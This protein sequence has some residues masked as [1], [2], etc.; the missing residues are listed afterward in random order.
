MVALDQHILVQTRTNTN[1][2]LIRE[3]GGGSPEFN[4]Q[5]QN[6]GAMNIF[7]SGSTWFPDDTDCIGILSYDASAQQM[8]FGLMMKRELMRRRFSQVVLRRRKWRCSYFRPLIRQIASITQ[9]W[10]MNILMIPR[11]QH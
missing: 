8:S 2:I 6:S 9:V 5:Q 10:A 11:Q 3:A 7:H 1:G 4:V